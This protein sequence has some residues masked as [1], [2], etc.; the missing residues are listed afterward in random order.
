MCCGYGD[1]R[2]AGFR[3]EAVEKLGAGFRVAERGRDAKDLEFGAAE[4][5][6][7]GESVVNVIADVGVDDDF[8]GGS[9]SGLGG[10]NRYGWQDCEEQC[11]GS[12]DR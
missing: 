11:T 5:Q 4:S 3:E 10:G 6:G 12:D 9:R 8:F 2:A 1:V 7:D